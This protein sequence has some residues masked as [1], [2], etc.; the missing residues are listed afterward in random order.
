MEQILSRQ[1]AS[2][3]VQDY[4]WRFLLGT[5]RTSVRV[6]SLAQAIGLAADAIAVCGNDADRHLRGRCPPRLGRIHSAVACADGF[7]RS[8]PG[9]F[10][11]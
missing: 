11:E 2:E 10:S 5:L 6:G 3:A 4:D 8:W 9:S 1:E 7:D